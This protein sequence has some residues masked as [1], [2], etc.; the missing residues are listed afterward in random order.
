MNF[1][2][3]SW[4][5]PPTAVTGKLTD[6]TEY[7]PL[8]WRGETTMVSARLVPLNSQGLAWAF[9]RPHAG[10]TNFVALQNNFTIAQNQTR[11]FQGHLKSTIER[12]LENAEA[13]AGRVFYV[14]GQLCLL[15]GQGAAWAT[16]NPG[17]KTLNHAIF[18]IPFEPLTEPSARAF[19]WLTEQWRD[20][21]SPVRFAAQWIK[22]SPEARE[23][24]LREKVPQWRE[25]TDLMTWITCAEAL[26]VGKKWDLRHVPLRNRSL[27]ISPRLHEWRDLLA[28]RFYPFTPPE[29]LP[30]CLLDALRL[31]ANNVSATGAETTA[32]E[33][34]EAHLKLREWLR[35]NAPEH[36]DLVG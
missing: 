1:E 12:A 24:Y 20:P 7:G 23:D 15:T 19:A 10:T 36:L 30:R 25:L 2:L 18:E 16:P 3:E 27:T 6:A 35:Q 28:I 32:H 9:F 34:L 11:S 33:K 21:N 5:I 22:K 8:N 13:L 31:A 29:N 26:P 17:Y 14:E 4:E